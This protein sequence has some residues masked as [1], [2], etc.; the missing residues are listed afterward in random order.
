MTSPHPSA[1]DNVAAGAINSRDAAAS[2]GS[3]L[4]LLVEGRDLS[5][6]DAVWAMS[7]IVS[8]AAT[9]A[10]TA[11]LLTGLR[12]KGETAAEVAAFV[13]A[14]RS[15]AMSVKIPG[16]I[17]DIAGTGGDRTGAV[18][19]STMAAVVAAATG[20][21][22]V[23]HGGR[24]ASSSSAG[25]ADLL[26]H[27]GVKLDLTQEQVGQVALDAG[28]AYLFAPRF[29]PGL[30]H[31]APVRRQLGIPTVF[32]AVAPLLNPADPQ[33]QVV[34]VADRRMA[35]VVAGAMAAMGRSGLVVR[36]RDGLDNLTTVTVSDVWTVRDG[37][38][39]ASTLDPRDLGVSLVNPEML[40]GGTPAHNA[41]I[42]RSLLDGVHGPVRD[43]VLLNAAAVL[44]AVS[45]TSASL[46]DS[47][48]LARARCADALDTGAAKAK[49]NHLV[50]ASR[51]VAGA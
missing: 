48:D 1:D 13:K 37:S 38:V 39:T 33:H 26:E 27:L 3:V 20:V 36:G 10:Q 43:A 12:V 40:R 6:A 4:Q 15:H 31:A 24:S 2:W 45:V 28:M 41:A 50:T 14:L 42:F 35:P 5:T 9:D 11:A 23:K 16:L 34:G 29:N 47:L 32:N 30:R 22:V 46:E 49:L 21:T 25:S 51:S 18:N 17:V 44:V 19:I 8:G 7:Q